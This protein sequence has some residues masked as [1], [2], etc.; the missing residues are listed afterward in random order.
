VTPADITVNVP[1]GTL[2]VTGTGFTPDALVAIDGQLVSSF[3]FTPTTLEAEVNSS[4]VYVAASHQITVQQKSGT[5][6]AVTVTVYQPKQGPTVMNAVPGFLVGTESDAP[7]VAAADINGDGFADVLMPNDV[8]NGPGGVAILKG[9]SNGTLAAPTILPIQTP[10]SLLVGDVDGDGI[11][12]LVS[13][14]E[15]NNVSVV[16]TFHGDGHGNFQQTASSQVSFVGN[17]VFAYLADLNGDGLLDVVYSAFSYLQWLP[18]AGGGNF[19]GSATLATLNQ[20][21]Y[22]TIGDVNRDGLP[23]I[24]YETAIGSSGS[25]VVHTLVNQGSGSFS[26][27]VTPGLSGV[28]GAPNLIDFNLDGI[29]D[30]VVQAVE[31][32]VVVLYSF[33]GKGDGSFQQVA[34]ASIAP[35]GYS[36]YQF[37]VGDF[38]HDG[39]PDLAGID[40]ETEPSTILYLFGDG[41][42]NFTAQQ[43]VGP[44]GTTIAA[45]DINGD[46]LPDV[47]V[48]DRFSFVSVSLGRADRNF[49]SGFALSPQA[50]TA[51]SAGDING[52]GLA[53][54]FTGGVSGAA[55]GTVFQNSGNDLLQSAGEVSPDSL[56]VADLTGK[57]VVDLIG[58]SSGNLTVWPN[59]RTFT[60]SSAPVT[61]S[62]AGGTVEVADMDGDG[63]PDIVTTG[64]IFYGDGAYGF[65]ALALPNSPTG[66]YVIGDF[67][68]DGRLDIAISGAVLVNSGNRSFSTVATTVLPLFYGVVAAAGDL[69][70]DGRDDVVISSPGDQTL[71]L[72]YGQD[73]GTF[74]LASVLYT[75]EGVGGLALGDFDGDGRPDIAA[76][77][78][79]AQQAVIFFNLGNGQFSW[80]FFASGADTVAMTAADLNHRG[81]KDLVIA[82]FGLDFRPPNENVIFHK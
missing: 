59:N 71:E 73:D 53:D 36:V 65:T 17:P 60:F 33:A 80:S 63:H 62:G 12:D 77:L 45:G 1:L 27:V 42:G 25:I 82:N 10:Y 6:N 31:S 64:Q 57:G 5:S 72:Y 30:L 43:V 18:N 34:R 48:A 39:F 78:M 70:G 68:G 74:S 8:P 22:F 20:V 15:G 51:P 23:D 37:V 19:S 9:Q 66:P 29:P 58:I 50:A 49:P 54:V 21:N 38:D 46:H 16:T 69:N 56:L 24:V 3:F 47:L 32:G 75:A 28:G 4:F 40:G 79:L 26:D 61:L 11:A 7:W 2:L 52:D 41:R 81:K 76:G 35:P 55:P 14:T 13:I 67:N 44:Q